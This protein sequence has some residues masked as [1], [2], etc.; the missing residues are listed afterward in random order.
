[1]V[2][3]GMAAVVVIVSGLIYERSKPDGELPTASP[4]ASRP[5]TAVSSSPSGGGGA[6]ET[7]QARLMP[8]APPVTPPQV[9]STERAD[10]PTALPQPSMLA[11][12]RPSVSVPPVQAE[13]PAPDVADQPLWRRNAVSVAVTDRPVIA[14]II[15]DLGID[16][17]R[18]ERVVR[19]PGPLTLAWLP[20]ASDLDRQ[21]AAA[22]VAGHELLVH[23]PMEPVGDN[24]DPGPDALLVSLTPEEILERLTNG[25][26]AFDGYVGINN[27][28]GSR[29]TADADRMT[30]VLT[31]LRR[32]GLLFVDSRTTSESAASTVARKVGLPEVGRDVFLDH[33]PSPDAVRASLSRLEDAARS[34]G[35]AIGIGHPHDVT[36]D[37]LAEWLPKLHERGFV[38]V[39]VSAIV[40]RGE[41]LR[42]E[43]R[44]VMVPP[45]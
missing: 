17:R 16:K 19:L 3:G 23:M 24:A 9:E 6:G 38:L 34:R 14:I 26:N 42:T 27:H 7:A 5:S 11:P 36:T 8:L 31:E 18:A 33:D 1:M 45:R 39:P 30:V 12:S 13:R 40:K 35:F 10:P 29:F 25:L 41:S 44:S 4:I 28:M 37:A 20:Y 15:D 2:L 32:R 22:R 43:A 21:T